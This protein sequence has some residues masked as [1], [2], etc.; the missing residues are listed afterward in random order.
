MGDD[1]RGGAP[2]VVDVHG[3]R[4]MGFMD[5]TLVDHVESKFGK[6]ASAFG[7]SVRKALIR[8]R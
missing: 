4:G 6:G 1:V 5:Q 3:A 7:Y 8:F 2:A